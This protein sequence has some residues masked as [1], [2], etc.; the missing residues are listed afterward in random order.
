MK[1][2]DLGQTINTLANI[3]VIA[4]I[5]FLA[6][7]IQ[8]NNRLLLAEAEYN[9]L[10]NRLDT[11]TRAVTDEQFAELL[12]KRGD[13][14]S[15]SEL[16]RFQLVR[17]SMETMLQWQWEYAQMSIGNLE[18][19]IDRIGCVWAQGMTENA[20]LYDE[21]YE[22]LKPTLRPGFIDFIDDNLARIPCN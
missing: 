8:Q 5:I 3:G 20:E 19:D 6:I 15:L 13:L 2:I 17:H 18:A 10:Q 11:S 4:G 12:M 7:E 22:T 9:Y 14:A 1:K 16:E 21:A